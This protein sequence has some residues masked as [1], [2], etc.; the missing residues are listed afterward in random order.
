ME[1]PMS[2]LIDEFCKNLSDTINNSGL[3]M[4]IAEIYLSGTLNQLNALS[5]K[6]K[7]LELEAY[8]K[9]LEKENEDV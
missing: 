9:S 4:Y 7:R 2:I 1:K 6:Q 8:E 3:P 5:A